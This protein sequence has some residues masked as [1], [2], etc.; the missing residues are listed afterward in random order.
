MRIH[1]DP[2]SR[3]DY[4]TFLRV[5]ELPRYRFIGRTAEF[6][7]EYCGRLGINP[8]NVVRADYNP[9][10]GLFDYQRDISKIAIKKRKYATFLRCGLGKTY[11]QSEFTRHAASQLKGN[12]CALMFAPPMVIP[13]T[14]E[15]I[16]RF[17][18]GR[19][20]VE[21]I[22]AKNLNSWL[23]T[24]TSKIGITSY[25]ALSEDT[26]QGRLGAMACDETSSW[27][28]F[29]GKWGTTC[30]R[31]GKGLEW[32]WCG[33]GTPAP[34]D[35]IEYANHAVFLDHFPNVNS[36]LARYFVNKGK[37]DGRWEMKPHGL[38]PFYKSLSHWCIFLND[39]A[40]YGWKDN[41]GGFPPIRVH[42]EDVPMSEQQRQLAQQ[43]T[44]NLIGA[45]GGIGNRS[46]LGQ[47]AKGSFQ[48]KEIPTA[49]PEYIRKM[50][51][52][53]PNDSTLIFCLF[54]DEQERLERQMP[55]AASI[56]GATK[57][58]DR[59]R[60]INQYKSGE[61]KAIISKADCLGYGLNLQKTQR[62]IFSGLADSSE[63][64]TQC[65]CRANRVG[66]TEPLEVYIPVMQI[67]RPMI[68]TVLQKC[69]R[70]EEDIKEQEKLFKEIGFGM[71]LE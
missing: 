61:Q 47:I 65:V 58:E 28:S 52:S 71:D 41:S 62:M 70:V 13:Q 30:I 17:Y 33:T 69:H 1:L 36:F 48:G 49:K 8:P 55:W 2:S 68:E 29:G 40:T 6:P 43:V 12:Q 20:A 57:M 63:D 64:Y 4:E 67:E 53:W 60:M 44:G 56:K 51:E 26:P 24:G 16:D 54:N 59:V 14:L 3:E 19:M 21:H 10:N 46:K 25:H 32:K 7:D 50:V 39:P 18:G 45:A 27:K 34:N 37:T 66:S 31:L 11:L 15:E 23:L 38:R 42:I 35:R 5:K 9:W 22:E